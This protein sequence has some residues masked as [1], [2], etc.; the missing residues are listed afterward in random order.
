MDRR[1]RPLVEARPPELVGAAATR[2]LPLANAATVLVVAS[3]F[4]RAMC[5]RDPDDL[6]A[7]P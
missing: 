1:E 5:R 3:A 6:A 7:K 4:A 2:A